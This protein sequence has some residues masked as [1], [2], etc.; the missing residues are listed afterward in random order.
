MIAIARHTGIDADG[1]AETEA[2]HSAIAQSAGPIS[3]CAILP[4]CWRTCAEI[5]INEGP[6]RP[7]PD[8]QLQ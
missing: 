5:E 2:D 3:T 4:K 7:T 1:V 8:G 6:G